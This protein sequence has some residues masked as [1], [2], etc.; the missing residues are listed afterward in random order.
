MKIALT[1]LLVGL[2]SPSLLLGY[3]NYEE[4]NG[5]VAV[6]AEHFAAQA[7]DSVRRWYIIKEGDKGPDIQDRDRNHAGTASSGAY[8]EILPDTR[9][10]H[11]DKLIH[12]VNFSNQPGLMGILSYNIYFNTPGVY[13]VWVRAFSTGAEDNGLHVG[14]DGTWPESGQRIQLCPGKYQWT[15]SSAQRVPENHCGTEGTIRITIPEAGMHSIHFSM[16][17]DGFEF[18]KFIMAL[19]HTYR[20]KGEAVEAI[21]KSTE[22][23][24]QLNER[25]A[26]S[27]RPIYLKATSDFQSVSGE[28][29]VP[30]YTDKARDALA[31]NA[32]VEQYRGKFAAAQHQ[33]KGK[34]GIYGLTLFSM[35]E[36]DGESTYIVS[37]NGKEVLKTENVATTID[38]SVHEAHAPN[39]V[40]LKPGDIIQVSSNAPTNGLIPEGNTTAYARGRWI[41]LMLIPQEAESSR[42]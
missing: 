31:I 29:L 14:L 38:Y 5:I 34:Q 33:F 42:H 2:L 8:L 24:A 23:Y 7:R 27:F 30:Y 37:I 22:S 20:P 1:I 15:W 13:I 40:E 28:A 10:T 35:Q 41:E 25:S 39:D 6:E 3:Q 19:D 36:T 32:A 4:S 9:V 21:P 12:G 17:E 11:S 18:D 26:N 16:R